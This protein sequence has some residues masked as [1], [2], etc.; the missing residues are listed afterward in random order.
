MPITV[1]FIAA[2]I[3]YM[4]LFPYWFVFVQVDICLDAGGR[5][6][7]ELL[8]CEGVELSVLGRGIFSKKWILFGF[9]AFLCL[10]V[11]FIAGFCVRVW[12]RNRYS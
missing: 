12:Q 10:L 5:F 6:N 1:G 2:A 4:Y 11:G 3:A 9:P 7:Y 8:S